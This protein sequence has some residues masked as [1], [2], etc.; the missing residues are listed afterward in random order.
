MAG[1]IE[2]VRSSDGC[3]RVV[4]SIRYIDGKGDEVLFCK[5]LDSEQ[6]VLPFVTL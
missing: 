6:E 3:L 4:N 2:K 1:E 5:G